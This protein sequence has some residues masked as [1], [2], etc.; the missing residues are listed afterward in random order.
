MGLLLEREI[1]FTYGYPMRCERQGQQLPA[2][3]DYHS[4]SQAHGRS[5][6]F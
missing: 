4:L 3:E 6:R 5:R 2:A 1:E